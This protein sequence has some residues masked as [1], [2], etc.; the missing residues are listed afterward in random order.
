MK[1]KITKCLGH[2]KIIMYPVYPL[3]IM[4]HAHLHLIG[5][6][7]HPYPHLIYTNKCPCHPET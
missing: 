5:K 3:R 2:P 7:P 6:R 1:I 4:C